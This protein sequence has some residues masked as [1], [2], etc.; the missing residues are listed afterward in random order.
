MILIE[1]EKKATIACLFFSIIW[2]VVEPCNGESLQA[3]Q[4]WNK[5]PD[6]NSVQRVGLLEEV[7]ES[8]SVKPFSSHYMLNISEISR[9]MKTGS[10]IWVPLHND[11]LIEFTLTENTHQVRL[12]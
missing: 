10:S 1:S 8:A 2:A 3:S 6:I 7:V 12:Y 5:I 9:R 11:T 4:I